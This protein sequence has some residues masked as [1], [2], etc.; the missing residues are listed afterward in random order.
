MINETRDN[1]SG[2]TSKLDLEPTV[3]GKNI[4]LK[5]FFYVQAKFN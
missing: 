2:F 5:Y 4:T 3:S 1:L